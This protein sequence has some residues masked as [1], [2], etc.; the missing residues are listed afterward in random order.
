MQAIFP[1][2]PIYITQS[3]LEQTDESFSKIINSIPP[4]TTTVIST[5][6]KDT[7]RTNYLEEIGAT[8]LLEQ[9]YIKSKEFGDALGYCI[10]K[11]FIIST[12]LQI[13]PPGTGYE[14]HCHHGAAISGVLYVKVPE[15]GGNLVFH[16]PLE[17]KQ[18]SRAKYKTI[19]NNENSYTIWTVEAKKEKIILFEPWLHHSVETNKSNDIRIS[20]G[21]NVSLE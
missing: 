3:K 15:N 4:T 20:I 21:F 1:I 8:D 6:C 7:G 10:D 11:D 2:F 14:R 18:A 5:Y 17:T 9:I 16:S 19:K 13:N 12:W